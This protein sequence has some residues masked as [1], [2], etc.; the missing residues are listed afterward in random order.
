[1]AD[2]I[3]KLKR[4]TPA[5][6]RHGDVLIAEV[7]AIPEQGQQQKN[8]VLAY[9]E[10]TGHSHCI[11]ETGAAY[12]WDSNGSLFLNVVADEAT[13]VHEEHKPITL[14]HG[15]YRVWMQREY[16]PEEIRAVVD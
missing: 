13:V 11:A 9:G 6:W 3:L 7:D 5:M 4:N 10:V 14:P 2:F 15:L 12:V 16:S 1:M 8:T